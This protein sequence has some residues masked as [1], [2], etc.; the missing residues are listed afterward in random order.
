MPD[1]FCSSPTIA[2]PASVALHTAFCSIS[3]MMSSSVPPLTSVSSSSSV[4]SASSSASYPDR[5]SPVSSSSSSSASPT[6]ITPLSSSASS[7]CASIAPPSSLPSAPK[8]VAAVSSSGLPIRRS[9]KITICLSCYKR[10]VKCDR[11]KPDCGK[12]AAL[13]IKCEYVT[14]LPA[15]FPPVQP[16]LEKTMSGLNDDVAAIS[17][18]DVSSAAPSFARKRSAVDPVEPE[19][20]IV[21]L[22]LS[23]AAIPSKHRAD[24]KPEP[25]LA[26]PRFGV[27]PTLAWPTDI[28][29]IV[30]RYLPPRNVVDDLVDEYFDRVQPFLPLFDRQYYST[31]YYTRCWTSE[32]ENGMPALSYTSNECLS[33]LF[34]AI[35]GGAIS[36]FTRAK[37]QERVPRDSESYAEPAIYKDI[38]N[39][40]LC[41]HREVLAAHKFPQ[42]Q[43]SLCCLMSATV[44]LTLRRTMTPTDEM[45]VELAKLIRTAQVM[46]LHKDD[47]KWITS[48]T[49]TLDALETEI[50]RR[51]WWQ[52]VQLDVTLALS[53]GL[54]PV[55]QPFQHNVK[56]PSQASVDVDED[57]L[58]IYLM[59]GKARG[60]QITSALLSEM[61]N[62][63]KPTVRNGFGQNTGVDARAEMEGLRREINMI[64]SQIRSVGSERVGQSSPFNT[65]WDRVVKLQAVS[66]TMLQL[67]CE[68]YQMVHMGLDQTDGGKI[69][70][71]STQSMSEISSFLNSSPLDMVRKIDDSRS[72]LG[73]V[74]S[75]EIFSSAHRYEILW[76][77]MNV[78]RL[79]VEFS[80]VNEF[81]EWIWT[82][83]NVDLNTALTIILRDLYSNPTDYNPQ[84]FD[85]RQMEEQY[86]PDFDERMDLVER[87]IALKEVFDLCVQE[88]SDRGKW[89]DL[90]RVKQLVTRKRQEYLFNASEEALV[91]STVQN[92]V[93]EV[94]VPMASSEISS[95][96]QYV[97]QKYAPAVTRGLD[98]KQMDVQHQP[99]NMIPLAPMN[100]VA[101]SSSNGLA[102]SMPGS[103][104]NGPNSAPTSRSGSESSS[105]HSLPS[106]TG[107]QTY[108]EQANP[109][110]VIDQ[111]ENGGMYVPRQQEY[112][113]AQQ[114]Q[115]MM[116]G[117][118]YYG[119]VSAGRGDT[120]IMRDA[121]SGWR[122]E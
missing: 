47:K 35:Y 11:V 72:E 32:D 97:G 73:G 48:S 38:M 85:A 106:L 78:L 69:L 27:A 13:H 20:V 77:A 36:K 98:G 24:A 81:C 29:R 22:R 99:I 110:Y 71:G 23:Y 17:V 49:T 122:R 25:G 75:E 6:S 84:G 92:P 87:G 67:S 105:H 21:P 4:S 95:N 3:P 1:L 91:A 2:T 28:K 64:N 114:P 18:E 50:R 118:V 68:M 121:G 58:A 42:E 90:L 15:S 31:I 111:Q 112:T 103:M 101:Y 70:A 60:A 51:V 9:R 66:Q 116:Q 39:A 109:Q 45:S 119:D 43:L 10:R 108:G 117:G 41:G 33:V 74:K 96:P 80:Q 79:F 107:G 104:M 12:C 55:I 62:I 7:A 61:Y 102:S 44:L 56:L 37:F 83:S 76:P 34:T 26:Y 113:C 46:G 5:I 19:D 53:S 120:T 30:K 16:V 65:A 94:S 63:S 82:L 88:G 57:K 86:G 89:N 54:P 93:N 115:P 40:A 8:S 52:L 59:C 14:S 100:G